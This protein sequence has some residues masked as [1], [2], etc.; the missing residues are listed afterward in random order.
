MADAQE[1]EQDHKDVRAMRGSVVAVKV[2]A[3]SAAGEVVKMEEV[4]VKMGMADPKAVKLEEGGSALSSPSGS[5]S[6]KRTGVRKR[7]R[8][9]TQDRELSSIKPSEAL[10]GWKFEPAAGGKRNRRAPTRFVEEACDHQEEVMVQQALVNSRIETHLLDS[11]EGIPE[12][13]TYR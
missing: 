9:R 6:G 10:N 13:P 1:L 5:D 7:G 12:V 4:D 11:P 2:E 8:A 3:S